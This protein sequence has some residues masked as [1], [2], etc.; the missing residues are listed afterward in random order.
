MS[1]G[2]PGDENQCLGVAERLGGAIEIRRVA[3]KAPW[4]WAMPYGPIAPAD[5][6]DKE[7]SPLKGPFPDVA[8]AS[9]RRTVAYLRALKKASPATT[10]LFL[11]DPRT[12]NA[13]ADLIWVPFHDKR[14]GDNVM[15]TLTGPHRLSSEVL[16]HAQTTGPQ[17]IHHLPPA[18]VAL[19]L[20][21]DTKK[22]K[23]G[24]KAARRLGH[25]LE[26]TLPSHMSVMVTPSRRTPPHVMSEVSRAL[27]SRPHW[28]WDGT[29]DNPYLSMLALADAIIVTADSHSMLSDVLATS[30]PVY[31]FEPDDYPAKLKVTL[32]Q[33]LRQ[34][35]V[36]LLDSPLETGSR[37][38][39][40]STELIADELRRL[41]EETQA[42]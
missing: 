23:F 29:G 24:H 2:K 7:S 8:I 9:G 39:I 22:E 16:A 40:D 18:R 33:L 5:R 36:H 26:K 35:F 3:P 42:G 10:T 30:A 19:I 13:G 37:A 17:A 31:I 21:G 12:A 41:I 20:G 11:K 1:D 14:R 6:P 15:V 25:Y 38:P 4:V 28:I 27:R 34:P 32:R